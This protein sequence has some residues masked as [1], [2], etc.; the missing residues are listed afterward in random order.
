MIEW[1]DCSVGR[2]FATM[3]LVG[4][5]AIASFLLHLATTETG[6]PV[7]IAMPDWPPLRP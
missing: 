1:R 6:R 5:A 3:V 2:T 7:K 4:A